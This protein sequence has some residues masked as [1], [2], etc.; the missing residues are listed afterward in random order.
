MNPKAYVLSE[1]LL[2]AEIDDEPGATAH[3]GGKGIKWGIQI[4]NL[5]PEGWLNPRQAR[6][7]A[8]HLCEAADRLDK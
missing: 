1:D 7:L 8:W 6:Q 2:L 4:F 5:D 3:S